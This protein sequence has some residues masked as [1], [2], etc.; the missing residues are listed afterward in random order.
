[1]FPNFSDGNIYNVATCG[2]IVIAEC[3]VQIREWISGFIERRGSQATQR[4]YPLISI[5]E[6][7]N[8]AQP[9]FFRNYFT[10]GLIFFH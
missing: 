7:L 9:N 2:N 3:N 8:Y 5:G 10:S 1:M 4:S 6:S